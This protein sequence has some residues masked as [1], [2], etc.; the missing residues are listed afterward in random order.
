MELLNTS[1]NAIPS[2]LIYVG[3]FVNAVHPQ[4]EFIPH[5]KENIVPVSWKQFNETFEVKMIKRYCGH[6]LRE[7]SI[8]KVQNK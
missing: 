8:Y 2:K 1:K 4:K 3:N 6:N 7:L 5:A